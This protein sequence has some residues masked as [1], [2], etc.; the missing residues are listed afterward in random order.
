MGKI[1]NIKMNIFFVFPV[2]CM[3]FVL[4]TPLTRKNISDFG[5]YGNEVHSSTRE[6]F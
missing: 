5:T 4:K 3:C 1:L 2:L 6:V